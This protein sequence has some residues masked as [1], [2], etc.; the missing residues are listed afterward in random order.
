M[1]KRMKIVIVNLS[2]KRKVQMMA[3]NR[4]AVE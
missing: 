3:V 2:G 1:E 4:L